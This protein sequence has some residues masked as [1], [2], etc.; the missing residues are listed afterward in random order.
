MSRRAT[1]TTI[2]L[3]SCLVVSS[4]C[5]RNRA[6][7]PTSTPAMPVTTE[8]ISPSP[9]AAPEPEAPETDAVERDPLSG[10]LGE[11]NAYLRSQGA[12]G[13]I[14]FDYDQ[15]KLSS[16]ARDQLARS[17]RFMQQRPEFVITLEGHCDERGTDEYNLALGERR[18]SSTK[19]YLVSL[20]VPA[21]RLSTI[22]YGEERSA[23]QEAEESCWWQNRRAH[24][25]VT[26]R[27]DH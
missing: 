17:A 5:H 15:S 25:M 26:G 8:P 10:E 21:D 18:A 12:L 1:F 4:G 16:E 24:P 23:C 27:S 3:F 14:Y 9:S 19:D 6:K 20:G 2:L 13:D 7:T 22:S 11:I